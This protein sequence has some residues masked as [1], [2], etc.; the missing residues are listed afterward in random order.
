LEKGHILSD[1][2]RTAQV[3]VWDNNRVLKLFREGFT[4]SHVQKEERISRTAFEAG[5]PVPAVHGII[6]VEGR[7]GIVFNRVDGPLMMEEMLIKPGELTYLTKLFAEIHAKMHAITVPG[8]PSQRQKLTSQ[9]QSAA[10]LSDKEREA[11]LSALTHLPDGN[12]LCHGDYHPGNI[13]MSSRGPVVIDCADG[14]Q[15]NPHADVARSLLL[16]QTA[17]PDWIEDIEQRKT[18]RRLIQSFPLDIYFKRYRELQPLS[19]EQL[20]AWRLPLAAARLSEGLS[21]IEEN[22]LLSIVDSLVD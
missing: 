3:L 10:R 1:F 15:G 22:R 6:E 5:L 13:I 16:L 21:L 18:I 12:K 4:I 14:S 11:A 2:G 9:I 20:D 17:E 7:Y 19:Q 8:F